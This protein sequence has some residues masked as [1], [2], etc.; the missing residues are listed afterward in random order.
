[1]TVIETQIMSFWAEYNMYASGRDPLGIRNSSALIFN[2]LLPGLTSVTKR[3]RLYGFYPWILNHYLEN[4]KVQSRDAQMLFIRRCE[5]LLSFIMAS[6]PSRVVGMDGNSYADNIIDKINETADPD[7]N[8]HKPARFFKAKDSI[9]IYYQAKGG[10]LDVV[11]IGS[12]IN[13]GLIL[14]LQ[15]NNNLLIPTAEGKII[16][17]AFQR[18][19]MEARELFFKSVAEGQIKYSRLP[20]LLDVFDLIKDIRKTDEWN[21]YRKLLIGSDFGYGNF[22]ETYFRRENIRS[23][24][25]LHKQSPFISAQSE[26]PAHYFEKRGFIDNSPSVISQLW[27]AAALSEKIHYCQEV[28]FWCILNMLDQGNN[29][30]PIKLFADEFSELG[31]SSIRDITGNK[32]PDQRLGNWTDTLNEDAKREDQMNAALKK[33]ALFPTLGLALI[34]WYS[35]YKIH[36]NNFTALSKQ[37]IDNN[38]FVTRGNIFHDYVAFYL[39]WKDL[40]IEDCLKRLGLRLI[41]QHIEVAFGKMNQGRNNVLR[42]TIDDNCV[43]KLE[44]DYPSNVANRVYQFRTFLTDMKFIDDNGLT[45]E[46]SKLLNELVKDEEISA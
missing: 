46:G 14:R 26:Y 19:I 42:L 33:Q 23:F 34:E 10:V 11:Y 39:S 30:I 5:V 21:V 7:L 32:N 44:N 4:N 31:I 20:A 16:A 15:D 25:S 45:D 40:K 38:I 35:I 29:R 28:V 6:K 8:I 24:L 43:I 22:K 41:N 37:L 18:N 17:E 9:G 12:L 1:M 13:L 3:I 36:K 2:K 27:Y